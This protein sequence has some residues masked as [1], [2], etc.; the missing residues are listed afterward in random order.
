MSYDDLKEIIVSFCSLEY[1]STEEIAKHIN[2]AEKY[3]KNN[4]LPRMILEEKLF[5]LYTDNHPNQK[6]ISKK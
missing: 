5:R 3:L 6:Y 4:I 1:R 2:R